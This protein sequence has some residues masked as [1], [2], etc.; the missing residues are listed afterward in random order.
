MIDELASSAFMYSPNHLRS[1]GDRATQS[2]MLSSAPFSFRL[3]GA[4]SRYR[5]QADQGAQL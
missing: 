3:T 4:Q 1:L 5:P 2:R